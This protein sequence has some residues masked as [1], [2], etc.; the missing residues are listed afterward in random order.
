MKGVPINLDKKGC[1]DLIS[2]SDS[3][4]NNNSTNNYLFSI[5]N[6]NCSF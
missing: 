2:T 1:L 6:I 5:L 4:S 3:W